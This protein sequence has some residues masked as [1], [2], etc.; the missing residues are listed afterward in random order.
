MKPNYES[1]K[2]FAFYLLKKLPKSFTH[3]NTVHT[4][5]VLDACVKLG[6]LEQI[7]QDQQLLLNTAAL[8]HDTGYLT[9]YN[10]NEKFGVKIAKKRLPF[11]D[12]SKDQIKEIEDM[13]Y[14][15]RLSQHNSEIIQSANQDNI[16]EKIL[17]DADLYHLGHP[18]FLEERDRLRT[19]LNDNGVR[20]KKDEW[21]V[22][23]WI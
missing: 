5:R 11:F 21:I 10:N 19:E 14:A 4:Q 20:I 17:C 22:P 1:A 13:I 8:Y 9:R 16:L 3:H 23:K 15:T 12:Y 18:N 2:E 7:N 6:N